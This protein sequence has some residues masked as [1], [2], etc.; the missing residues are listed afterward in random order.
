M[1]TANANAVRKIKTSNPDFKWAYMM[2]APT[3]IGLLI[4]NIY[5]F[6]LSIYMSFTNAS[7][8]GKSGD[9]I[10][11]ANYKEMFADSNLW[12]AT[13]NT[14]FFVILSVP[15]GIFLALLLGTMLNAKIKGRDAFRAIFFLPMVVAPAA[16][17]MVWKWLYN[18]QFG[19]INQ[20][21]GA[22]GVH[23]KINWISNPSLALPSVALVAIW[24]S[25]G[26]DVIM[27]LA[28]LQNIPASYYE[29]ADIDGA[30]PLAKFFHI[31]IPMVS[32]T[33]FFVL[34]MRLMAA[35]KQFDLV[36]MMITDTNPAYKQSQTLMTM[37]YRASF[38]NYRIGYAS[39]IVIWTFLIIV[40]FTILQFVSQKKWVHYD[41]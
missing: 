35:L 39:S 15:V 27:I 16:I 2:I 31:T 7:V 18:T 10:G 5:P 8:S 37:F 24:S 3:I 34:M 28:G 13:W 1:M 14:I 26:Y 38:T 4:L 33:L 6:F 21:L 32:P 41:A 29:A 25:I 20:V 19:L 36:Y 12:Q 23:E 17:S 30:T 9:F 11:L 40:L 22:L